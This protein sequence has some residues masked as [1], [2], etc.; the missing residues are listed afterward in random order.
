MSGGRVCVG[1]FANA[2]Y[3]HGANNYVGLFHGGGGKLLGVRKHCGSVVAKV[4]GA[5]ACSGALVSEKLWIIVQ[6][7]L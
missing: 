1:L 3:C 6:A 5:E 4:D 2:D 7:L